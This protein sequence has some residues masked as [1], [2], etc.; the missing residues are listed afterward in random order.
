M[1][2]QD[3]EF[4]GIEEEKELSETDDANNIPPSDIVSFNE[5]RSCADL[6]RMYEKKQL[7]ID[8]D[9]Q[10]EFVWKKPAQTKF[11]D[12]LAKQLPIPSI[13]ISLDMNSSE[14]V[15]IDGLQRISSII[16]FLTDDKWQ[17]S[18]LNDITPEIS[19]KTVKDIK[20]KNPILYSRVENVIIPI[21]IIRCDY[22]KNSHMEFLFTIFHRLNSGG[23][24]L[25]NQEI[26]NCIFSGRLNDFIKDFVQ[27]DTYVK[28][29][30][31]QSDKKY[32]FQHEELL[33]RIMAFYDNLDNY[34]GRLSQFLNTYMKDHRKADDKWLD[35]KKSIL[36]KTFTLLYNKILNKTPLGKNS[37]AFMEALFIGIAQN[38]TY[39]ETQNTD[40]LTQK[41]NELRNDGLFSTEALSYSLASEDKV[42]DRITRSIAIF[43]S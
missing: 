14:R 25:N 11:I 17:L 26:R 15:V 13:C 19:G 22:T 28:L 37:K 4:V 9:F 39:L 35:E 32:R 34:N 30:D 42:K 18:K 10:R 20:Q 43:G 3:E 21:T 7:T 8:P 36:D 33:L 12:S 27:D 2:V 1:T 40:N 38:I 23:S 31:I 16:N 24:K 6:V 29:M 5:L 41:M